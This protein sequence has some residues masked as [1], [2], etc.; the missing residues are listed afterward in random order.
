MLVGGGEGCFCLD[1]GERSD[2]A[3]KLGEVAW[4]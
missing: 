3:G 4:I 1:G 2:E